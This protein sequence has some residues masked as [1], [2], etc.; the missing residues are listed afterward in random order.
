[1][2]ISRDLWELPET[3]IGILDFF[4]KFFQKHKKCSYF[5]NF[6]RMWLLNEPVLTFLA[7]I[8]YTKAQFNSII[9]LTVIEYT[10]SWKPFFVRRTPKVS[11]VGIFL[12]VKSLFSRSSAV[13]ISSVRKIKATLKFYRTS[14]GKSIFRTQNDTDSANFRYT[15]NKKYRSYH[16]IR[17]ILFSASEDL[18]P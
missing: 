13:R 8:K 6:C 4:I 2:I 18:K 7:A 15:A 12:R 9:L 10:L 16:L 11:L 17:I 3:S 14:A 5:D 1:M